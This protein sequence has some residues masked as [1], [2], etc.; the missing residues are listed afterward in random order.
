MQGISIHISFI[1]YHI[2]RFG[3]YVFTS[4]FIF[5]LLLMFVVYIH[6]YP[7]KWIGKQYL[8]TI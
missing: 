2:K 8:E 5:K 6:L 7:K 1:I 3:T 4:V